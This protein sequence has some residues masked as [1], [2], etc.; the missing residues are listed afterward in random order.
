MEADASDVLDGGVEA[1]A[2]AELVGVGVEVLVVEALDDGFV[3]DSFEVG[4]GEGG[5]GVEG[6][7]EAGLELVVVAVAPEVVALAEESAVL[8]GGERGV[9]EAVGGAEV[10]LLAEE[11]GVGVHAM[12]LEGVVWGEA[13][14]EGAELDGEGIGEGAVGAEEDEA[15]IGVGL[16]A[17]GE[18]EDGE[19][20]GADGAVDVL[21]VDD[22]AGGGAEVAEAFDIEFVVGA[23]AED[24]GI[25]GVAVG[26]GRGIGVVEGEADGSCEAEHRGTLWNEVGGALGLGM[27]RP[28]VVIARELPGVVEIPEGE[29]RVV[30]RDA[31]PRERLAEAVRGATV[32]VTWVS[33]R[34]DEAL[35]EAAGPGLRAVCNFA[36]GTDN[37]DL[38]ACARRGVVVTNTPDAVTE[39][40]A[41][42]AWAL[43]LAV[44]R[45][46]V[47]ADRFARSS[48][49]AARGPLGP[50]EFVG[51]DLTGRRLLIVGAGRIGRA[52]A[53]RS[54]GW[55]MRVEYVAR[56]RHW[57]F[58]LAPLA[59]RRVGLEEGLREADVVSV[60]TPLTPETRGLIGR[61][62]I[63]WMK[64]TAILVNT[65]RGPIV[66][67]G[68]L[69]EALREGRLFGAGL[70]VFEREP[71]VHPGLV[72]LENAVLTPHIG[73]AA[74]RYREMMTEMVV[75]NVRAVLRGEGPANKVG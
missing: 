45:R 10:E 65:S 73:S 21:D 11:D 34:V 2:V 56:T 41:D 43:L 70:D 14:S 54:I 1:G 53:L 61:R 68:A 64:R 58:E 23:E 47:V 5:C 7:L 20:G 36:V 6:E 27:G 32:L 31:V 8:V 55:G 4:E 74:A 26:A 38:G 66:D 22:V 44:A 33:E 3:G 67:E 75:G 62:E 40:T 52:V 39:G 42:L 37:I 9:V 19:C 29:V 30:G 46:L 51:T 69:V 18:E 15:R 48:E 72:G 25:A 28:I 17:E 57:D 60:H 16:V 50:T 59:A 35:L 12:D 49:Y 71:V 24:G 63:G 13:P